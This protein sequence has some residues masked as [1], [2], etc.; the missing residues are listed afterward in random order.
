MEK[1]KI[2]TAVTDLKNLND[3]AFEFHRTH[4]QGFTLTDVKKFVS[5]SDIPVNA[6][7]KL[8]EKIEQKRPQIKAA[9]YMCKDFFADSVRLPSGFWFVQVWKNGE[10]KVVRNFLDDEGKRILPLDFSDDSRLLRMP[11][12]SDE[13][14][15]LKKY[16]PMETYINLR[17]AI[18][19]VWDAGGDLNLTLFALWI[20][21]TYRMDLVGVA[22]YLR[23]RG[24]FGSGKTRGLDVIGHCALRPLAVGPS[25]S[26]A[27]IFRLCETYKPCACLNEFDERGQGDY[28]SLA[29]QLLNSRYERGHPI[30]R[31]G[32][33]EHDKIELFDPF[34]PTALSARAP[35]QDTSLESRVLDILC[36]ETEREDIPSLLN[37]EEFETRFAQIRNELYLALRLQPFDGVQ[38]APIGDEVPRRFKQSMTAIWAALPI[39]LRPELQRLFSLMFEEQ[40]TRLRESDEGEIWEAIFTKTQGMVE[41]HFIT[42]AAVAEWLDYEPKKYSRI[43]GKR[44]KSMGFYYG[45]KSVGIRWWMCSEKLWKK[46]IKRMGVKGNPTYPWGISG[47]LASDVAGH[48][49][50]ECPSVSPLFVN[51]ENTTTHPE[52]NAPNAPSDV[53]KCPNIMPQSDVSKCSMVE[54]LLDAPAWVGID[55]V[56]YGPYTKGQVCQL[57]NYEV[58]FLTKNGLVTLLGGLAPAKQEEEASIP[59]PVIDAP[60]SQSSISSKT[61]EAPHD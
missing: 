26:H 15:L 25:M 5:E 19:S 56:T 42:S 47:A 18:S 16:S 53:S 13:S 55:N 30:G 50:S 37:P 49:N 23:L 22:P 36:I 27:L 1:N 6:R 39:E 20:C 28:A 41:A 57:P 60:S 2:K 45:G 12:V 14:A 21:A 51:D 11:R 38:E 24:P 43:F 7:D 54:L 9:C 33:E 3:L 8:L 44:L 46:M 35:F 17:K 40:A 29:V 59:S 58:T 48:Q 52:N 4:R 34:G 61:K 32:G 31:V 10:I